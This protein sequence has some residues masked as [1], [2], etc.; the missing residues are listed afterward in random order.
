[1]Q[2]VVVLEA[3]CFLGTF[4]GGG[5]GYGFSITRIFGHGCHQRRGLG[6]GLLLE[7][8]ARV[9]RPPAASSLVALARGAG[10]KAPDRSV[11]RPPPDACTGAH[12]LP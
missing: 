5:N 9:S 2:L 1:M 4:A 12:A 11:V 6:G 10:N 7:V 8:S 3:G